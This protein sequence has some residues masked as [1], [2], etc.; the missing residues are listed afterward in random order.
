M[1]LGERRRSRVRRASRHDYWEAWQGWFSAR[2][3]VNVLATNRGLILLVNTA[4]KRKIIKIPSKHRGIE[5]FLSRNE[6]LCLAF[7]R[8]RIEKSVGPR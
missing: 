6:I 4:V 7:L 5:R 8:R 1:L 3:R 2:A